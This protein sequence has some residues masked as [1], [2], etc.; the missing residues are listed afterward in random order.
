M[1]IWVGIGEC[2]VTRCQ[3]HGENGTLAKD[4]VMGTKN[5]I[6]KIQHLT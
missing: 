2:E 4:T 1:N 5:Y 6:E 3:S